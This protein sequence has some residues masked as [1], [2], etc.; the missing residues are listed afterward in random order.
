MVVSDTSITATLPNCSPVGNHDITVTNAAGTSPTSSNDL[1]HVDPS[2][3]SITAFTASPDRLYPGDRVTFAVST[4]GG[5]GALSYAYTNLPPG[6]PSAN[7]NSVS[8]FPTSS[9]NYRVTVTVTDHAGESTTATVNIVVGPQRVLGLP[10]ALG[11]EVIFGA[12]VGTSAIVILST[13]L[14]LRLKKKH[15]APAG[16]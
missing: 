5:Y 16:I 15:R 4:S 2:P 9:G 11:L 1:F 13:A 6:C 10:Q 14:A 3:P 8:C 7:S 12:I